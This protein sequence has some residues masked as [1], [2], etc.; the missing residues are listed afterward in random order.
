[1]KILEK[2]KVRFGIRQIC[3]GQGNGGGGCGS[4]LLV[5]KQD[6]YDTFSYDYIGDY[7]RYKT[8][9][10]PLCGKETDIKNEVY[11]KLERLSESIN[12]DISLIMK[13]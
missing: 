11:Y 2:N 5:E 7:E 8:F 9:R 12:D 3:T 4:E 13:L 6:I 10:C 1:M